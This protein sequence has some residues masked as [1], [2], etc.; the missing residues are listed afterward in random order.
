MAYN[1]YLIATTGADL[2]GV[3]FP[4]FFPCYADEFANWLST[5]FVYLL[6]AMYLFLPPSML[7][8]HILSATLVYVGMLLLGL[9]AFRI[10]GNRLIGVIVGLTAMFTPWLFDLSRLVQ[11]TSVLVLAV[12]LFLLCLHNASRRQS[13]KLSDVFFIALTLAMVTYAYA[14]GRVLGPLFALGL[15]IFAVN[16]SQFLAVF[17][18]WVV[19]GIL[20]LP[21]LALY[22]TRNDVVVKRFRET[23]FFDPT[24]SIFQNLLKFVWAYLYDISPSFLLLNGDPLLRHH[25]QGHGM[26]LGATFLLAL[27]GIVIVIR[28]YRNEAWWR[29]ALYGLAVSVLPGAITSY[30]FHTLR[31]LGM[32]IFLLVFAVPA[33]SLLVCKAD[34]KEIGFL[35]GRRLILATLLALTFIQAAFYQIAFREEGPKRLIDFNT[36]YPEVFEKALARPERPIYLQ[37]GFYGPQYIHA[38]WYGTLKGLDLKQFIR[39]PSDDP[40][41]PESLVLSS[42]KKCTRCSIVF[43]SRDVILYKTWA[44]ENSHNPAEGARTIAPDVI[45][46]EGSEPGQFLKPSGIASAADGSSYIADSLNSRI[47]KFDSY[48]DFVRAFGKR[49]SG[50]GEINNPTGVTT[51][52]AGDIYVTDGSNH[53]LLKFDAEGNF[54]NEWN[55]GDLALYGP[56]DLVSGPDKKIYF[57]DS[58]RNRVAKFDPTTEEFTYWGEAGRGDGQFGAATGITIADQYVVVVESGNK[59]IQVFDLDGNFVRQWPVP[60]WIDMQPKLPDV[61]YDDQAKLLYVSNDTARDIIAFDLNGN[62]APGIKLDGEEQCVGPSAMSILTARGKRYLLVLDAEASRLF[63]FE[64]GN[65]NNPSTK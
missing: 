26:L 15:I 63:K 42:A 58:G 3:S 47:E 64:L 54:I 22:F 16:K 2:N 10:S 25:T 41:P 55:G 56:R 8:A 50:P 36:A 29:F 12:I 61:I 37:D 19:Y 5:E 44:S 62:V 43:Q 33:L 9:L 1:G 45:G 34:Q 52:E 53:K 28:R 49:G 18:T 7:S 20:F 17:K 39:I 46:K 57:L 38:L 14:G 21:T 11:E 40:P 60:Q 32:S 13:W 4:L 31:L 6:A 23:T 30:R 48:L 35:A 59:R 65:N 51:D 24:E 27:A